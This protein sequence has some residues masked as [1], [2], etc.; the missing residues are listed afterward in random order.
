MGLAMLCLVP[1]SAGAARCSLQGCD[2][3]KCSPE[4]QRQ[5]AILVERVVEAMFAALGL[6]K[7]PCVPPRDGFSKPLLKVGTQKWEG[8]LVI[9][10]NETSAFWAHSP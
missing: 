4:A 8:P 7:A 10:E 5:L 3:Q 6:R 9:S 2:R 1:A